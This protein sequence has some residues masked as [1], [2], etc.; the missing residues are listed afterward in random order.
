M[1]H[2]HFNLEI[3]VILTQEGSN[4]TLKFNVLGT[5]LSNQTNTQTAI[6]LKRDFEPNV[7]DIT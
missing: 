2:C 5:N 3:A 1:L 6:S 7:I 4:V